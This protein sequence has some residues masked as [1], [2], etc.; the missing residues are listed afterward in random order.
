MPTSEKQLRQLMAEQA[1]AWYLANRDGELAPQQIH[2]FT[3]WLRSSPLH[4]AEYLAI[5]RIAVDVADAARLD[6]TPLEQLLSQASTPDRVTPIKH[7]SFAG[8]SD[9]RSPLEHWPKMR[10]NRGAHGARLLLR[11]TVRWAATTVVLLLISVLVLDGLRW[12]TQD[13][14]GQRFATHHGE[15]RKLQLPDNT[16]VQLNSDSVMVV[17]F[18]GHQRHVDLIQGEAY[19]VVAKDTLRPF[20]VDVDGSLIRDIGTAFDV[21]RQ[22]TDTTVSVV[23]GQIQVS[24]ASTTSS[25]MSHWLD[26][27]S[28]SKSSVETPIA[29]VTAGHQVRINAAGYLESQGAVDAQQVLAWTHGQIAFD[30]KSIAQVAAQFNRYNHQQISVDDT[31]IGALPIS[32][33]FDAHDVPVFVEFLNSLPGVHAE[34]HGQHIVVASYSASEKHRR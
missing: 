10:T 30:D 34:A 4:I 32:G 24:H 20:S 1:A 23:E 7:V 9:A 27:N 13:T 21:Y 31:R 26:W 17:R 18:D 11:P 25:P 33:T 5:A 12:F 15:I 14:Q 6:K 28:A 3:Y 29:N 2:E 22:A 16:L 19:F 8:A